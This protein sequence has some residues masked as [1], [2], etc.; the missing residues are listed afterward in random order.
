MNISNSNSRTLV[1]GTLEQSQQYRCVVSNEAG[2]T[3]SNVATVTV[4]SKLFIDNINMIFTFGIL[5][6]EIIT[7]PINATTVL[8][9]ESVTL[10]CSASIDDVKY[11]WHRVDGHIPSHSQGRHDGT[12]TIHRVTPHNQGAYYCVANKHGIIVRSD[13]A[14][15]GVDGKEL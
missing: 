4:L 12:F 2:S 1:V 11:S 8:A 7:Q 6:T 15:I 5:I 10:N 9:L 14:F 3:R 13:D